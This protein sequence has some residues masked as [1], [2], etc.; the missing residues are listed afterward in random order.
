VK[1]PMAFWSWNIVQGQG[2]VFVYPVSKTP[3]WNQ[4]IFQMHHGFMRSLHA[5][6]VLLG[7][8][9]CVMAWLPAAAQQLSPVG[10]ATARFISLLLTYYTALHMFGFPEP[11]YSIPLRPFLYGMSL[12]AA[13]M[14]WVQMRFRLAGRHAIQTTAVHGDGN[15]S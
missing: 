10:A 11:R 6:L 15:L 1:K 12:F 8:L 5:P 9:G 13:C 2:D 14:I 3:Y 7:L 4:P